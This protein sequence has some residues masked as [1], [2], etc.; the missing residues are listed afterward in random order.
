MRRRLTRFGALP[1][2]RP[3]W[4]AL[5]PLLVIG[6]TLAILG[7]LAGPAAAAD[8]PT[9]EARALLSGNARIGSWMAI[10]VHVVNDGPA[11]SGELRLAG[12]T[13]G[14]TRFGTAVDLPTQSSTSQRG[15]RTSSARRSSSRSTMRPS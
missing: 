2:R 8:V 9:I 11:I 4:L 6:A 12:G 13:Q 3:V 5:R 10:Q 7:P 15:I 1:P 14:Q